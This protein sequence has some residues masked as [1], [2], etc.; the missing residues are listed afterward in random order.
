MSRYE[1]FDPNTEILGQA[2]LSFVECSNKETLIPFLGKHDLS[3]IQPDQWYPVQRWLDVL[4]DIA[5]Q[6]VG[7]EATFDFVS[8]GIKT[9][10]T[11]VYP[12]QFLALPFEEAMFLSNEGYQ[13]NHRGG[14]AG[15]YVVEKIARKHLR[16]TVRAPY[17]SDLTYGLLYGQA[18]RFLP[19]GTPFTVTYDPDVPRPEQGG[20]HTIIH[21]EWE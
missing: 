4:S 16:V 15:E 9:A 12:P 6:H 2:M 17:P 18:R 21:I 19:P 5:E 20:S 11:V 10:E 7:M 1:A 13:M 8:V 3:N 14:D